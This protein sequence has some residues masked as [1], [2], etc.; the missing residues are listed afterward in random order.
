MNRHPVVLDHGL[1]SHIPIPIRWVSPLENDGYAE[2]RDRD[3]LYRLDIAPT[4]V[5]LGDFWPNRGPQWDALGRAADGSVVLVEA[6]A[7][8]AEV[9]SGPSGAGADSLGR[10]RASLDQAK[11]W[12]GA[13]TTA[14]WN[15]PFY[16]YAN[17]LAHLYYL[18]HLNGID[19]HLVFVYFC[20]DDQMG[21]PAD[22]AGWSNALSS[23]Y[24]VLGIAESHPA[25]VNVFVDVARLE[26][27]L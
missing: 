6:K 20:G 24:Q 26:G 4:Q 5:P 1:E 17:R 13:P 12:F 7:H 18:S 22:E 8:I 27:P 23:V 15:G 11:T 9:V 19:T 2:Y 3:A 25:V 16:Q 14:E 10:I 21:G